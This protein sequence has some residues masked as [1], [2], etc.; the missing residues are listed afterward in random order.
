MTAKTAAKTKDGGGLQSQLRSS[1]HNLMG[2]D[3]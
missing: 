2:H 3:G 1:L